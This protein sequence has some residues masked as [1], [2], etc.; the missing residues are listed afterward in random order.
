MPKYW[1]QKAVA[2]NL[3]LNTVVCS[4]TLD[5]TR[6]DLPNRLMH[7]KIYLCRYELSFL[8]DAGAGL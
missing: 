4:P 5:S 1:S 7:L 6:Q 2:I 3:C 8:R